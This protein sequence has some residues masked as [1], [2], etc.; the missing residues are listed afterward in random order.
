[1]LTRIREFRL[2]AHM[3]QQQLAATLSVSHQAVS[4]WETGRS[5]PDTSVM[6]PLCGL[7]H[8]CR[9]LLYTHSSFLRSTMML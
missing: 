4:K 7:L 3:T 1:M 8:R 5:L 9:R 2:A 6:L